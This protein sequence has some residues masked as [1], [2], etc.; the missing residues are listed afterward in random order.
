LEKEAAK[1]LDEMRKNGVQVT[2][3]NETM[4][5]DEY[6][7]GKTNKE[8]VDAYSDYQYRKLMGQVQGGVPPM[9]P[10]MGPSQFGKN[11]MKWGRGDAEARARIQ[12]LTREELEKNG[13]TKEMAKQWRDFYQAEK[14]RVP[15][16]PSAAGRAELM[17]KAYELLGGE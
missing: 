3:K 16:N 7:R 11:V 2:I 9:P 4:S 1:A 17:Q 6:L 14:A 13:V 5:S 12:S 8:I 15:G 10:N